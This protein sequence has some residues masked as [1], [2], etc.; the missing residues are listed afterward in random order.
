[1]TDREEEWWK[2]FHLPE[3]GDVL[4]QRSEDQLSQTLDFLKGELA[5]RPGNHIFDQCCGIGSLSL[6]L[7]QEGLRVTGCDLFEP[8]IA[9][10]KRD[11]ADLPSGSTEFY[12]ADAFEYT[13][14]RSCEAAFNWYSSFGYAANDAVNQQMLDRAF[15]SLKPGG[16]FALDVPSVPYLLRN[17]NPVMVQ[18]GVSQGRSVRIQRTSEIEFS[19]GLLKQKWLWEIEGE[20]RVER[21]SA[22]K[23]YMPNRIT[24]L[25]ANSGFKRIRLF[26]DTGGGEYQMESPR[27]L[28]VAEKEQ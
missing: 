3:M 21:R 28:V 8:Y 27:L 5:L 9:R 4:L 18:Q 24:E 25:L 26:G 7:A 1:M 22:M 13:P 15:E 10:A 20:G 11:A 6:P 16:K 14:K 12:C 19:S 23:I 2:D 17:F